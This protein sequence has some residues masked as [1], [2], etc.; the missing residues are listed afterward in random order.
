[1]GK[2]EHRALSG[3][4]L[5]IDGPSLAQ[6]D[7]DIWTLIPLH[8]FDATSTKHGHARKDGKRPIHFNW[9]TRAYVSRKVLAACVKDNRNVGVRLKPDQLVIDVDP[10]NGGDEGFDRLCL[11]LGIDPDAFP[12]VITGSG[13]FHFY[14]S[15]PAD[16]VILDTLEAFPGV[17]FKSRGRQVVAAGSI[18]PETKKHYR[19]SDTGPSLADGFPPAPEALLEG[20]R[21]PEVAA[22][23]GGGQYSQEQIAKALAELD[24]TD[25]SDHDKWLRLMM[26]CHHASNGDARSEFIEW[27]TQDPEYAED[28][29]LI[30]KRW[31]SLHTER[32]DGVTYRTLNKILADA[33]AANAQ[34][35]PAD[36]GD[37]F[38]GEPIEHVEDD[39]WMEGPSSDA[40]LNDTSAANIDSRFALVNIGGKIR[41]LYWGKSAFDRTVRVPEF[42][43]E[44]EFKRALKNKFVSREVKTIEDGEE[45][46]KASRMPLSQ[47]WLT[48]RDRYTYD[49]L[50]FDAS[51]EEVSEQDEINLWRGFGIPENPDGDWSRM[52]E[53]IRNVIAAG[54][55]KS[56][57]YILRW[58]AWAVQNPTLQAEVALALLSEE[59]GTGKGFLG[60]A[61]CHL[62]GGHALHIARRNLLTGHFNAH[63]AMAAF[64]F[65]DEAIWPGYKDDEG[66]LKALIT[67]PTITIEPKGVNAYTMPNALKVLMA[68]NSKW[69]VPASGD[70]RRYAVFEVSPDRRQ[71]HAYFAALNQELREGGLGAMLYDLRAMDLDGWHPR[72]E[73][74]H[75]TA[76]GGQKQQSADPEL[77]WLAGYLEEGVLPFQHPAKPYR[78]EAGAFYA[79][80]RRNVPALGRWTDYEFAKFL[81]NWDVGLKRSNGSWR[82]F[83]PLAD[84]RAEWHKRMPWWPPFNPQAKE[85]APGSDQE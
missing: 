50:I 38:D 46:T 75:T 5:K 74:P 6:Y 30:G 13:G 44:D 73:I 78:V 67:E 85:W 17:E 61:M 77:K 2:H 70:E 79:H 26:A 23:Q 80:A 10:R 53:H 59:K 4:S 36:A 69:V 9:T 20:I 28:A 66:A 71:D 56:F 29:E 52:R 48:R 68:S 16:L 57:D 37:D 47:W 34:A 22:V 42:W 31:D 84:M 76:L 35:A 81:D 83:P 65:C 49:G 72:M 82:V 51:Q 45:K 27:S 3:T 43:T 19:W 60:R 7:A 12:C 25:F 8:H 11:E 62:F 15:K 58:L 32:N 41:I 40:R 64:V 1:M 39:S 21:R 18:H 33:G 54:D 63:F 14:M 55:A 24:P